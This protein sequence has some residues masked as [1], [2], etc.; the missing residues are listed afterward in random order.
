MEQQRLQNQVDYNVSAL[1][2]LNQNACLEVLAVY[3]CPSYT[4]PTYSQDDLY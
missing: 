2:K 3:R 4:G 1:D